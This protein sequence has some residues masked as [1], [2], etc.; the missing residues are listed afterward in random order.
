MK[1]YDIM[2]CSRSNSYLLL[3][4][5][6]FFVF[7]ALTAGGCGGSGDIVQI[8]AQQNNGGNEGNEGNGGQSAELYLP[9]MFDIR[10][11]AEFQAM[12]EKLKAEGVWAKVDAHTFYNVL[13]YLTQVELEQLLQEIPAEDRD[14]F[15]SE[16]K[17]V[18]AD[19]VSYYEDG[20]ILTLFHPTEADIEQTFAFLR[21]VSADISMIDIS[22]DVEICA[23]TKQTVSGSVVSKDNTVQLDN[24]FVY[25]VPD[26]STLVSA[27]FASSDI[28]PDDIEKEYLDMQ[29]LRWERYYRWLAGVHDMAAESA[30]TAAAIKA[31]AAQDNNIITISR[32]LTGTYDWSY[33]NLK[34]WDKI[35]MSPDYTPMNTY[36]GKY[37][38]DYP[39][40]MAYNGSR[41]NILDYQV[42]SAHSFTDHSDYFLIRSSMYTKPDNVKETYTFPP[43]RQGV[44]AKSFTYLLGY[45]AGSSISIS[46]K[47][48]RQNIGECIKTSMPEGISAGTKYNE[49]FT[50]SNDG[51]VTAQDFGVFDGIS[52]SEKFSYDAE[53]IT[54]K[55]L[56][57]TSSA[58]IKSEFDKPAE[59]S[60]TKSGFT[61]NNASATE[62]RLP[63]FSVWKVSEGSW[64]AGYK[65]VELVFKGYVS[66]GAVL[67][68]YHFGGDQSPYYD[69][70]TEHLYREWPRI[71]GTFYKNFEVSIENP[72][73]PKHSTVH[74][75]YFAVDRHV[76]IFGVRIYSEGDWKIVP[77][78]PDTEWVT[79]EKTGGKATSADGE[80]VMFSCPE[81]TSGKE[82]FAHFKLEATPY[83][84]KAN[85][86][87]T[88]F[89]LFQSNTENAYSE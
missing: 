76:G 87:S 2:K 74:Q 46:M 61:A 38:S 43:I 49:T 60:S 9:S 12:I 71:D 84:D 17:K 47:Q 11:T 68:N 59:D 39:N 69:P 28:S 34:Q 67:G 50:W 33:T 73:P 13:E 86:E 7:A 70:S 48:G 63:A 89:E 52:F 51:V 35:E 40:Y 41:S 6:A 79:F 10:S 31:A 85:V 30:N 80:W 16:N 53:N 72:N 37:H 29:V 58:D 65:S 83:D 4:V 77:I 57:D 23:I 5:A 15:I 14:R 22:T 8:P 54:V 75:R 25:V 56:S 21:S 44:Y 19:L 27:D 36:Q 88:P 32:V 62:N 20:G 55:N 81:N 18:Q 42:Y 66:E 64:K 82:R 3:L 26:I 1:G 78:D 45:T 24:I